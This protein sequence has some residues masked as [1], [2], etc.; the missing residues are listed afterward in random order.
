MPCRPNVWNSSTAQE[1]L[2]PVDRGRNLTPRLPPILLLVNVLTRVVPL[3][4]VINHFERLD[5]FE[6]PFLTDISAGDRLRSMCPNRKGG[7][8]MELA[9]RSAPRYR[10]GVCRGSDCCRLV[11]A[12]ERSVS[13]HL[14]DLNLP[15][16]AKRIGGDATGRSRR[17]HRLLPL[18]LEFRRC[19]RHL[20]NRSAD[21]AASPFDQ[22]MLPY[23]RVGSR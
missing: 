1:P 15:T 9:E 23:S 6:I 2:G 21:N 12:G 20:P 13:V 17:A 3:Y 10:N 19:V 4:I 8:F 16:P 18:T 11:G 5:H 7:V 14:G 22:S